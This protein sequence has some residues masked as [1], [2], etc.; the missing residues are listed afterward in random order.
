MRNNCII[1]FIEKYLIPKWYKEKYSDRVGNRKHL[2]GYW[3]MFILPKE[4]VKTSKGR[5]LYR[6]L[7]FYFWRR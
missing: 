5:T 2:S 1:R 6:W 4:L 3:F 7:N